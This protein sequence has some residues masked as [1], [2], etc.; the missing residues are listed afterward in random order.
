M[1]ICSMT[2]TFGKLEGET[3]EFTPGLNLISAP[4][5]WGKS[6]WCA[7][8][9]AMLYG[10]D[11]RQRAKQGQLPDKERFKPWSGK[12]MSGSM[13][14][15]WQ[16]RRVTIERQTKGRIP[17]GQFRAFETET[18]LPVPELTA[19]T[20]GQV[21]LG[22][23]RSVYQRTGFLRGGDLAV[24]Q[25]EALSQ[26]LNQL[27]TTGDDSPAAPAL[28]AGLRE[29]KNKCQYNKSGLLP[30]ARLALAGCREKLQALDTLEAQ[31]AGLS[32]RVRELEEQRAA[33]K[34]HQEALER[35]ENRQKLE[36]VEEARQK[37]KTALMELERARV[38]CQG[39]PERALAERRLAQ[40]RGLREA[41]EALEL[42]GSMESPVPQK[43]TAP[44][45][46]EGLDGP[47]AREEVRRQLA[48]LPQAGEPAARTQGLL[49]A[50]LG[51]AL[52]GLIL[53]WLLPGRWKLPGAA[54]LAAGGVLALWSRIRSRRQEAAA[55]EARQALQTFLATYGAPSLQALEQQLQAYEADWNRYQEALALHTRKL[56]GLEVRRKELLEE[57]AAL[58]GSQGS[59]AFCQ[60]QRQA[61]EAWD[62][63][64]SACR[65]AAQAK[66][67]REAMEAVTAGLE[68]A[69]LQDGMTL[70]PQETRQALEEV[71]RSLEG[72]RSQLDAC[73]G[74]RTALEDRDRLEAEAEAL[75]SRVA[76]LETYQTAL[77]YGL[78][79]LD[80]AQRE[81]Q[82]RFAPR[83]AAEAQDILKKLTGGRYD[84]LLLDRDLSLSAGAAG[85]DTLH[86]LVWRSDGTG[87]QLYL[88]LRLA[89]SRALIP[90]APLVLDDA[91]NRFDDARL[92]AALALLETEPR[93]IL[94][95]TCQ[96]REARLLNACCHVIRE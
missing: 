7:F 56:A 17:M 94:L 88:A 49:L 89:V 10:I 76:R 44:P 70:S 6:T 57:L 66:G 54:L 51:L 90:E 25:D 85:E 60:E 39:K 55:R 52:A 68:A 27:V 31:A 48:A 11:T 45:P 37:E 84:R 74:R 4:N 67:H 69:P 33:L 35:Q 95:F 13:E 5:E 63:L 46:L 96:D 29:L 91:L 83:I 65:A 19:D 28:A 79:A 20:C 92:A 34:A 47:A 26:R 78:A 18:G 53:L 64:A 87:D 86:P 61:L 43:P 8:L 71:N 9:L 22:V 23:E 40:W 41:L 73:R 3:L 75:A 2:A 59:E 93:Q 42:E 72:A 24:S 14:I 81:L 82:S 15:L 16:D 36:R 38:Q 77:G 58:T 62:L 12:P 50:S 32:A 1:R 21:L 80:K 30:Q